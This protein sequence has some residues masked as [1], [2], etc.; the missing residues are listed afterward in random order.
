M[1]SEKDWATAI[2]NTQ[3]QNYAHRQA[4]THANHNTLLPYRGLNIY[5]SRHKMPLKHA[6]QQSWKLEEHTVLLL[7]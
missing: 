2:W 3:F 1:P 4:D 6:E 5:N 7:A